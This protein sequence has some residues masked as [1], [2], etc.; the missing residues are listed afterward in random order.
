[1]NISEHGSITS[2]LLYNTVISPLAIKEIIHLVKG[3]L[4][5]YLGGRE[6]TGGLTKS[7]DAKRGAKNFGPI[8]EPKGGEKF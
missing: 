3:S 4:I 1:M 6:N 8:P 7:D 2:S 5:V